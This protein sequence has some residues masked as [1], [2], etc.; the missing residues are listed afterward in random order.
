MRARPWKRAWA[1]IDVDFVDA[2]PSLL[3]KAI[4][5]AIGTP[6]FREN[7]IGAINKVRFEDTVAQIVSAFG[8][9]QAPNSDNLF[10][11][12]FFPSK[13]ERQIFSK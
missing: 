1:V 9:K 3:H 10:N 4:D 2:F 13:S 11:S 8:I 5:D 6:D 7:G 12:S